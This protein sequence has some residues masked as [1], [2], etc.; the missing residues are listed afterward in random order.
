M[1]VHFSN[2]VFP[3]MQ[4]PHRFQNHL[5]LV[6][7]IIHPEV[8]RECFS[9][10][11]SVSDCE[12]ARGAIRATANELPDVLVKGFIPLDLSLAWKDLE[13]WKQL[14]SYGEFEIDPLNLL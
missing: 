7:T 5:I 13:R 10:P 3:L 6:L 12:V 14:T 1:K 9:P 4:N 2:T 11:L 8:L